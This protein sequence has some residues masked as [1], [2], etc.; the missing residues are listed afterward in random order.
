MYLPKETAAFLANDPF[1]HR[2]ATQATLSAGM[3]ALCSSPLAFAWLVS[4]IVC[5]F[6]RWPRSARIYLVAYHSCLHYA[7]GVFVSR[8]LKSLTWWFPLHI[9]LNVLA[10]A[11]AI[12]ALVRATFIAWLFR[13]AECCPSTC[14]L[15]TIL[16][17]IHLGAF[18]LL[19]C[20]LYLSGDSHF[21][22]GQPVRGCTRLAR[23]GDTAAGLSTAILG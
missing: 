2:L 6:L 7:V 23:G 14:Y 20:Y 9:I 12:A 15:C 8:Y 22:G 1:L 10:V 19:P 16:P 3:A 11:A 5:A 13:Y 18:C 21:D 4:P 17:V